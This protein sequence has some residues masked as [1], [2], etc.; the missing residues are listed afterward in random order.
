VIK[1]IRTFIS[2]L[3]ALLHSE[4][5]EWDRRLPQL[6]S[7]AMPPI[8]IGLFAGLISGSFGVGGGIVIVPGLVLLLHFTQRLSNGTSLLAIMPIAAAGVIGFGFHGSINLEY[9]LL[10]GLGSILGAIVGTRLLRSMSNVWL[11]RIFSFVLIF[12]A[13]WLFVDVPV[14][15]EELALTPAS[16]AILIALGVLAGGIAGL[17]GVGGGIILVPALL[18]FFGATA[19]MAKGTSL[20]VALIAGAVGS[21]SNYRNA[22][23]DIPVALKI[24]LAGIPTALIGAQLAIVMSDQVST[25]LFALLL[26]ATAARLLQTARKHVQ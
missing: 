10:L 17:L 1:V 13:I 2:R 11:A 8:L 21:L 4:N 7:V 25:V 26:L 15:S 12:T 14:N 3:I 22:N 16:A 18:L 23:I 20:L 5:Y 9:A 19:P 24:G 6:G